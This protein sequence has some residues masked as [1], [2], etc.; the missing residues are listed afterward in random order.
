MCFSSGSSLL[1]ASC[2]LRS[3]HSSGAQ[4]VYVW[5]VKYSNFFQ[6]WNIYPRKHN[7]LRQKGRV[8]GDICAPRSLLHNFEKAEDDI[9]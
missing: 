2:V 8:L 4:S 7:T 5:R 1:I 9:A 3:K 6:K